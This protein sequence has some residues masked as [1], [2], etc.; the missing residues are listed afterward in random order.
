[1]KAH[2]AVSAN[3]E[4]A[5]HC[6]IGDDVHPYRKRRGCHAVVVKVNGHSGLS[7]TADYLSITKAV[8]DLGVVDQ[9]RVRRRRQWLPFDRKLF[10]G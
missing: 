5:S 9:R 7:A 2:S 10:G 3:Q 1:M 6:L 8:N 4:R